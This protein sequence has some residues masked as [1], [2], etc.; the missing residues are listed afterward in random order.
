M[1]RTVIGVICLLGT[2]PLAPAHS[3]QPP[4]Q[5]PSG[6]A[7][8]AP[9]NRAGPSM[10]PNG[11]INPTPEAGHDTTLRPPNV[12]PGMTIRPPGTPG[13]NPKVDPK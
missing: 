8:G 2:G 3:E 6:G 11:V 5:P 1:L 10:P 4:G 13:G 12:D 9:D 7:T